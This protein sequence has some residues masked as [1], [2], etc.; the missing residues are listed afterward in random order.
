M[1]ILKNR[2]AKKFFNRGLILINAY[3]SLSSAL[4]QPQ[5]LKEEFSA[6]GVQTDIIKNGTFPLLIDG[7]G[8][9]TGDII[10]GAEGYDFCV[11]LDKD[12]YCSQLLEKSGLRLFNSHSAIR[13]CDDKAVTH[14]LLSQNGVPMPATMFGLLCYDCAAP[15][16]GGYL[17]KVE[18]TLG[19]PVVVK[20]SYGSL[21]KGVYK[22]DNRAELEVIAEKLKL[23]PHIFQ[24]FIKESAGTDVRVIVIG[25]KAV[26]AMKRVSHADFRSNIELGGT[27]EK[28][29][30]PADMA[31]LCVKTARILGLDYCGIDVLSGKDGY[32]ICEV[33]SNAFFGGIERVTGVNV[34]GEYA[35][36]IVKE[37]YG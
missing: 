30:C 21:G 15:V 18:K 20:E 29:D 24:Q 6:L 8:E 14:I 17:D 2:G 12:K 23:A 9:I 37:I 10:N 1:N 7:S 28:F 27:G 25:G 32:L 26:A 36:Y 16:S 3:S 35:K 5:R 19:Y 4:N 11:Y 22:A 34:A 31:R 13:A 33:N